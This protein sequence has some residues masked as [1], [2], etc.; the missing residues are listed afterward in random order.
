MSEIPLL[1]IPSK[2]PLHS[3]A[4]QHRR[5]NES[6]L[7]NPL[8]SE[9]CFKK[10]I[11]L[12]VCFPVLLDGDLVMSSEHLGVS[13][14]TAILRDLGIEVLIVEVPNI[15]DGDIKAIEEIKAFAPHLICYSLTTASVGHATDFG[16]LIRA[17]LPNVNCLAGGPLATFLGNKLLHNPNWS[18]LDALVRGEGDIPLVRYVEAFWTDQDY[19]LVPNLS[20]KDKQGNVIDNP[21]GVPVPDL[22]LLPEPARDQFELHD[23]KLPYLRLATTRGCTARCTFC[24]APHAGNKHA[25]GKLWRAREPEKIVDEIERLYTKYNFNTFDF[26]DSTFEDPSG[27]AMAK[28]RIAG[29]AQGIIDRNLK[30]YYNCCMQAKNWSEKDRDL[31][32]LL[33]KSGLEKV[34]I[35]IESGSQRG[36]DRWKKRSTVEDN[37]RAIGLLRESGVYVS[38]GFIAFH[39]WSDFEEIQEN[40]LFLKEYMG[41]NLRRFT[42][43]MELYPGAEAVEMLRHDGKLHNDFESTL[44]PLGYDFHDERVAKLARTCA[45]LYGARYASDIVI[46]EE[47]AVFEFETYD[48]VLHTYTSRLKRICHDNDTA[49]SIL[50]EGE[51][52][53]DAYR[54]SMCDFNYELMS[55]ITE[56]ARL[57]TLRD[58][59]A[60]ERAPVV[61]QFYKQNLKKFRE[62]QLGLSMRLHRAGV[63][64][65]KIQ[66]N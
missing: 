34:L 21:L 62:L 56:R 45:L 17:A 25:P 33:Y 3:S 9:V 63:A 60:L 20:W 42:V 43:R 61:Q 59:W 46:E 15:E 4:R 53:A 50:I 30:V 27:G 13:Y 6:S 7:E 26:V 23:S 28:K 52:K 65:R 12:K 16:R 58:E 1:F 55:E 48:I 64:V 19:S 39:P 29:I 66:Y 47:P 40:N 49:L 11:R 35:G 54:K 24:N 36:L 8:L 5:K 31:I 57:E 22:D 44:N 51:K 37:K 10:P 38:F 14:L 18:F 41:H 32:S 2:S